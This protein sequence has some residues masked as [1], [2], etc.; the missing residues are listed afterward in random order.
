MKISLGFALLL[1]ANAS[2]VSAAPEKQENTERVSYSDQAGDPAA[3]LDD[4]GWV[5]LATPTPASHGREYVTVDADAGTFR[6]IKL[7]AASGRPFVEAVRIRFADGKQRVVQLDRRL[8]AHR[9]ATIDL[10]GDKQ[11]SQIVVDTR[12]GQKATYGVFGA[13][14]AGTGVAR[15]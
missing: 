9:P 12:G 13:R 1:V 4:D 11:I 3:Q 8:A 5:E 10:R 7:T 2:A 6:Q 15:R 14:E